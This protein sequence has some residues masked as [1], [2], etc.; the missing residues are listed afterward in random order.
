MSYTTY[1]Q[2]RLDRKVTP[3]HSRPRYVLKAPDRQLA[4]RQEHI[5]ERKTTLILKQ[6]SDAKSEHECQI[7]DEDGILAFSATGRKYNDR[8]CKEIWDASGLP[9]FDIYKKP[10]SNP[11]SW[12]VTMPGSKPNG[13]GA[14]A[15]ASPQW[16]WT[17]IN[18]NFAFRNGAAAENKKEEEK[19]ISLTVKKHGEALAF[20][21]VV[22]GDRRIAE[23]RESILH[24]ERL[25]LRR[26][27]RGGGHRPALDLIIAPGVDSSLVA[28]IAII[29]SDW[30]FGSN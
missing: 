21:D 30:Y 3:K 24:N 15:Q 6:Y 12:V 28:A 20:F 25:A 26:S 8:S 16:S 29:V 11:F 10:L 14:I 19:E 1:T 5:T 9:L 18:L 22:D 23:V 4:F 27:S 17:S 2:A 7:T 13:D